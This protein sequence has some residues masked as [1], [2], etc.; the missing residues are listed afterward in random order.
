MTGTPGRDEWQR[1]ALQELPAPDWLATDGPDR[2]VC[3]S[4]RVR[5]MR[6][7]RGYPFPHRASSVQLAE[8]TDRVLAAVASERLEVH[9]SITNAERD[10]LVG[11]RLI[12]PEFEWTLPARA[13]LLDAPKRRSLMIH[14]EDHVR[15]Q[16]IL[17]GWDPREAEQQAGRL[18]R[19]IEAALPMA[20]APAL[21]FLAASP[22]NLGTG[23]RVSGMFQ[24]IGLAQNQRLGPIIRALGAKGLVVR[25]LFGESSRAVGAFVQISVLREADSDFIGACE[26]LMGE[27]RAARAERPPAEIRARAE[28]VRD[29]ARQSA[30]LSLAD[31]LR[32]LGWLRWAAAE[33]LA[34]F[35]PSVRAVDQVLA[36]LEIR[37]SQ[38]EATA[39]LGRAQLIHRL[40]ELGA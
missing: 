16:A 14:E 9:K 34:G 13:L 6:N 27:E 2:D 32:V 5:V 40:C 12:S 17:G 33:Q 15:L 4:V 7:V 37:P 26:Y 10:Y 19:P 20:Y 35:P 36:A 25:G 38:G 28:Q 23:R 22:S 29:F 24:L 3:L 31:A 21:G 30:I 11:C 39:S 8:I 18:L 1:W